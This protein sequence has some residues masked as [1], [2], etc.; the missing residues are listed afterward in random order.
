VPCDGAVVRGRRAGAGGPAR[1]LAGHRAPRAPRTRVDGCLRRLE[2]RSP[3]SC[4][5]SAP[6][7][8]CGARAACER[9]QAVTDPALPARR[10]GARRRRHR[11]ARL[12]RGLHKALGGM[13][14]GGRAAASTAY[15][16]SGLCC[17][18]DRCDHAR[19]GATGARKG[20][21][22]GAAASPEPTPAF[23]SGCGR[24]LSVALRHGGGGTRPAERQANPSD[25]RDHRDVSS[26]LV[27]GLAGWLER[28]RACGG[29]CRGCARQV[30]V[31]DA[32]AAPSLGDRPDDE[33][34]P[35][36]GVAGGEDA[37]A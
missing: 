4:S 34:L 15:S 14:I 31:D 36:A 7:W 29:R 3:L 33:R 2:R 27:L 24:P 1:R 19:R 37:W 17:L 21:P 16:S 6:S 32:G 18:R 10:A 35:A 5:S 9:D 22:A 30:S 13:C 8:R 12:Q 23:V 28:R 26:A 25:S 11:A 20:R